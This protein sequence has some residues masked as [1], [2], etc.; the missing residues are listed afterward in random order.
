VLRNLIAKILERGS[1]VVLVD[2]PLPAVAP[3][4][5]RP[6]TRITRDKN[7]RCCPISRERL[8]SPI[9]K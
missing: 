1:R 7:K 3:Q 6:F 2:L 9:W 5:V 8:E 4:N